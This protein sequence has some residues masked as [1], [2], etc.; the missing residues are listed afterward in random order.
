M[1]SPEAKTSPAARALVEAFL[2]GLKPEEDVS[3]VRY[4][5]NNFKLSSSSSSERGDFRF[6]R[7]PYLI[8]IADL[9]SLGS[10]CQ[11]ISVMKGRQ[12]GFTTLADGWLLYVMECA[13]GPFAFVEPTEEQAEDESKGRVQPA[14]DANPRLRLL[15]SPHKERNSS[16]TIRRKSFKGG[17]VHFL[18]A[19]SPT[20][21]R[22]QPYRYIYGDELDGWKGDVGGEGDPWMILYGATSTYS[23]MRKVFKT[24]TPTMKDFSRIEK[25]FLEG[26]RRR[27]HVPCPH[28]A[29]MDWIRWEN[30]RFDGSEWKGLKATATNPMLRCVNPDCGALIEER[31]KV[32]MLGVDEN[33]R[34]NG[35]WVA[36]L[37]GINED[38]GL[39][40]DPSF[41]ISTL[42]SPLGWKSWRECVRE[43]IAAKGD[44]S[45]TKTWVNTVLGE[46]YYEKGEE[47]NEHVLAARLEDYNWGVVQDGAAVLVCSVDTHPDRL[48]VQVVAV[49]AGEQ[50]W[51]VDFERIYGDP[52]QWATDE[53]GRE[54]VWARLTKMRRRL[55]KHA[56]SGKDMAVSCT[57]IDA[58]G[59]NPD[60]VYKYAKLFQ[61][62]KVFAIRGTGVQG[63]ELVQVPSD[64]NVYKAPMFAVCVDAGKEMMLH[65]LLIPQPARGEPYSP[66]Y[67]H[68][69]QGLEMEYLEQLTSE[70]AVRKLVKGRGW[71]R[72]WVQLRDR[73]EAW[74]LWVYTLVAYGILE[75]IARRGGESLT[76]QLPE[77]AAWYSRKPEDD[78]PE[79]DE[80][81]EPRQRSTWA[82]AGLGWKRA[83]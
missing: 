16:N 70:K 81:Q 27:F 78:P 32:T 30:I 72:S 13:P 15:V 69:P 79:G 56:L 23:R 60:S 42:Y 31:H 2:G 6:L 51:L 25:A 40:R 59:Y 5:E 74:D 34:P 52:D 46:T 64:A 33:A 48:E 9:L 47:L 10:D 29:H 38:T 18:G 3:L 35:K 41:Q 11:D 7:T 26:D 17:S 49:G 71:M 37:S 28:C 53:F 1:N 55:Y 80:P 45:R 21:L 39:P 57:A 83:A 54:T 68:L 76:R 65:R 63:R 19:N 24:S 73:N 12:L 14:I 8:E 82:L 4:L 77:I 43:F 58:G 62:E 44:A 20:K 66:K 22:R 75:F 61:A 50:T 67:V 36:E